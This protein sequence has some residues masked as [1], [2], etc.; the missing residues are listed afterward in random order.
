MINN[1]VA[2]ST[3][4]SKGQASKKTSGGKLDAHCGW[5][6][7]EKL[8]LAKTVYDA[9]VKSGFNS[10]EG[11][12]LVDVLMEV[13]G[14]LGTEFRN[15]RLALHLFERLLRGAPKYFTVF[16]QK[17]EIAGTPSSQKA[18]RF[19]KRGEYMVLL[20]PQTST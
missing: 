16:R 11:H 5:S 12:L 10:S 9:M 7:E 13:K 14:G 8:T 19:A 6:E 4:S 15:G 17:I 18:A 2:R 3:S 1:A 20:V